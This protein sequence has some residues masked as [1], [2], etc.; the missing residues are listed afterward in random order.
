MYIPL[1]T[2]VPTIPRKLNIAP[3]PYRNKFCKPNMEIQI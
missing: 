3:Y 2:A 1:K